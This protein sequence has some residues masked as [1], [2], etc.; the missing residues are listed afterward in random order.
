M[1][2]ALVGGSLWMLFAGVVSAIGGMVLP[3]VAQFTAYDSARRSFQALVPEERR[4]RVS[5]LVESYLFAFGVILASL[6]ILGALF[7]SRWIGEMATSYIYRW[8]AVVSAIWALWAIVK[9]RQ[10]YD[11]SMLDWRLKRRQRGSSVLDKLEF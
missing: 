2:L 6:I 8:L 7:L 4:G 9:M 10:V 11:K 1:P 5:M 3:K